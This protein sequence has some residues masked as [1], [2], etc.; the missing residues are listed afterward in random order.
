MTVQNANALSGILTTGKSPMD[1]Q[2]SNLTGDDA[3][4]WTMVSDELQSIVGQGD[5]QAMENKDLQALIDE[6]EAHLELS[7]EE[8]RFDAEWLQ[9]L[10]SHFDQASGKL[11]LSPQ[12]LEQQSQIDS[13]T[14]EE[15]E[16]LIP[17]QGDAALQVDAGNGEV[18]PMM[19]QQQTAHQQVLA[20]SQA[21][22]RAGDGKANIAS[23]NTGQTDAL[24]KSVLSPKAEALDGSIELDGIDANVKKEE[25]L[26]AEFAK[27]KASMQQLSRENLNSVFKFADQPATAQNNATLGFQVPNPA[28]PPTQAQMLPPALQT[29][30]L[31]PGTQAS[32]W[33][34]A[35]SERVAFLINSKLN[36]A[37]IRIDPP[38][39]GK[40]D[41]QIQIKDDSAVV[42]IQT[43]HAQ[44][45]DLIDSASMRL[46]DFLQEAGY[47]SVDVNVSHREQ[48]D[49]QGGFSE[50]DG[51][52]SSDSDN[53]ESLLQ[54][55]TESHTVGLNI[56]ELPGVIDY[57]A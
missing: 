11:A 2:T 39:L 56:T 37:E 3:E 23:V 13:K 34:N 28:Q 4:F 15:G 9:F 10:K 29:I 31:Q 38:H 25:F 5:A 48:G 30:A 17:T 42:M 8:G 1:G 19:W 55:S 20:S 50:R 7:G 26:M 21:P 27:D 35:I 18:L 22:R 45:R 47:S 12:V 44:T 6:F 32:E 14:G 36:R 52:F 54:E 43:Q 33:G 53:P 51:F 57:F 40:L 49:Q 16:L 46:R 24:N 41:I